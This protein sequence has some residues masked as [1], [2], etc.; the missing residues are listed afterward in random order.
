[1]WTPGVRSTDLLVSET[2]VLVSTLFAKGRIFPTE[3]SLVSIF[4]LYFRQPN[5]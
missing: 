1:M 2:G 5:H 4:R 3:G